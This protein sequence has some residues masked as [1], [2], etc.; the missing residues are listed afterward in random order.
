MRALLLPTGFHRHAAIAGALL[1]IV[2]DPIH[3]QYPGELSG[4]ITDAVTGEPVENVL[5]ESIAIGLTAISN[6]RGDFRMRGLE[7]G[8]HTLRFSRLGY[9]VQTQVVEIRNGLRT[10]IAIRLGVEPIAIAEVTAAA[11]GT[12]GAGAIT[13]PRDEI[14]R[15]AARTAADALVGRAGLVVQRYGPTG[16]QTVSI[17]GSAAD[18]VLVLLD[19]APLNG[20]VTGAADLS[21]IP[22]SQIESITVLKGSH[23][24]RYGPGAEAGVVLIETRASAPST[25]F[26][27]GTG[28]LGSWLGELNAAGGAG[29]NA[30]LSWSMGGHVRTMDGRYE[31]TQPEAIGGAEV[32]RLNGDLSEGSAFVTGRGHLAGGP[33]RV[34]VGHT[35]L[36]R[37]IPGRSFLPSPET[38]EELLRWNGSA[39]WE[40]IRG[41]T[42]LSA[43][44]D[45]A[46]QNTRFTDPNPPLGLPFDSRTDAATLGG[47]GIA[48][49]SLGGAVRSIAG[50]VELR[51]QNYESTTFDEGAPAGRTD[52]GIFAS[53]ELTTSKSVIGPR[54]VA[55]LRV[56]RDEL[57]ETWRATHELAAT[58]QIG[59]AH[60]QFRHA[61]SY[62][63]PS[64]GDQYFKEG[65]AVQPNPALRP[66]RIPAEL[67]LGANVEGRMEGRIVGRLAVD[68]Y[69]ADVKDM[70]IWS[71]DFRFVWSP[72]NFDVKRRGLDATGELALPASGLDL[73]ASYSYSRTT[74]DRPGADTIQVIYRP[75]HMG[76]AGVYWQS[77]RWQIGGDVRYTGLRYP[78]PAPLNALDAFWTVDLRVRHTFHLGGWR[79]APTLIVDRLLDNDDSLIFGY[80]E[81]GRTV[82]LEVSGARR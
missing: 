15:S 9:A 73:H 39:G 34:S 58:T 16:A 65:V 55:G 62:S 72:R 40:R 8:R 38:R 80:P 29:G 49:V 5:V 22:S 48:E 35:R 27:V 2:A 78:V 21:T 66:E 63:P 52:L 50:G 13:I 14:E 6:G 37:G 3:A 46:T 28:S 7:P 53:T 31:Y 43:M 57:A 79:L 77:E 74:Y 56:D 36:E 69:V 12:A 24:A 18:E 26:V 20:P 42:R 30:A 54:L 32:T 64:P 82:R 25:G 23:S 51:R 59:P 11:N 61:S 44:F 4:K 41:A 10:W 71:P 60:F 45:A 67:S 19:G 76:S 70:I 17:R 33:W 68:G 75:R 81:P 47:R 1:L